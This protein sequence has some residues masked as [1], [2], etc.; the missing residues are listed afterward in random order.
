VGVLALILFSLSIGWAQEN[1]KR[2]LEP[3]GGFSLCI[4]EGWS[5][6][7]TEGEK[8]KKIAFESI[9]ERAAK[10]FRLE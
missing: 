2:N 9:F 5:V 7:A 3:Q 8:F 10:S 1:C 4:P 6:Q